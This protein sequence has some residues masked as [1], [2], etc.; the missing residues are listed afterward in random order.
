MKYLKTYESYGK[1]IIKSV[2][3]DVISDLSD[4]G[5]SVKIY[6]HNWN[7]ITMYISKSGGHWFEFDSVKPSI[8]ELISQLKAYGVKPTNMKITSNFEPYR[9]EFNDAYTL[10]TFDTIK[11]KLDEC[12]TLF[13]EY[14]DEQISLKPGAY[15]D[16]DRSNGFCQMVELIFIYNQE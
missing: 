8:L 11:S 10:M 16:M 4:D 6:D 5:Y 12:G 9:I 15:S 7:V 14:V 1:D 2:I 3:N 13:N